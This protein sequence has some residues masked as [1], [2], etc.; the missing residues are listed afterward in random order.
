MGH[1]EQQQHCRLPHRCRADFRGVSRASAYGFIPMQHRLTSWLA[2]GPP[3]QLFEAWR[4]LCMTP[5]ADTAVLA[6]TDAAMAD[7][8]E[9][10]RSWPPVRSDQKQQTI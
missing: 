8:S 2:R 10:V 4:T 9:E 3:S 5:P 6:P 1:A 7:A